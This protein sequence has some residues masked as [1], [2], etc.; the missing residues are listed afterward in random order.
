MKQKSVVTGLIV[1]AIVSM[2]VL[3]IVCKAASLL[4]WDWWWVISPLWVGIIM[5][6]GFVWSVSIVE[7]KTK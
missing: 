5:F 7:R 3:N 1:F 4:I 6:V 2:T